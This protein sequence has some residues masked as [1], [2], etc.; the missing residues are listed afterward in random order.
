MRFSTLIIS[1]KT[2]VNQ[3][4]VRIGDFLCALGVRFWRNE[5]KKKQKTERETNEENTTNSLSSLSNQEINVHD[6]S[7]MAYYFIWI[8]HEKPRNNDNEN[9]DGKYPAK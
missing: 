9:D 6:K 8:L 4:V 2:T 7:P 3:F 5:K 1:Y